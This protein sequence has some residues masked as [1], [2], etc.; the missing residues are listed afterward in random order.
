[1]KSSNQLVESHR[2]NPLGPL[3]LTLNMLPLHRASMTLPETEAVLKMHDFVELYNQNG[4]AGIF[5]VTS[6]TNTYRKTRLI[7]LSHGLDVF[8]DSCFDSIETFSGTVQGFLQK[9]INAQ[10]QTVGT[11]KL[12]TLGTC[13]DT[14][15]WTKEIKYDNLL[16]C[17]TEIARTE[18]DYVFTF[19]QNTLPWT[20]NFVARN[21]TVMSEFRLSRNIENC[22]VTFDDSDLCTRLHLSVTT[23]STESVTDDDGNVHIAGKKTEEGYYTYNDTSAQTQWGV[24]AK[25]AGVLRSEV[26]TETDLQTWVNAYFSR[27]NTPSLQI[28]IGGVELHALTG[29]SIDEAYI[30]RICQVALP[31]YSTYFRERI[32]SV[33]YPDALR[34]PSYV[35]V[36]LA[37]KRQTAED[38]FSEIRHTASKA[39]GSAGYALKKANNNETEIEKEKIRYDLQVIKDEKRFAVIASEDWYDEM[40]DSGETLI[41][42]YTADFEATA[43]RISSTLA[44]TGV[45]VDANGMPVKNGDDY[46]F[47][48]SGNTLYSQVTQTAERISAEVTRATGAESTLASRITQTADSITAEV[49]RATEAEDRLSSRITVTAEA[50][51]SKVSAGDIASTINQT[52]QSV[53]IQAQK[54]DLQGYVTATQLDAVRANITNLTTGVTKADYL[55]A[56]L[57]H[58]DSLCI[59]SPLVYYYPRQIRLGALASSYYLGRSDAA[60]PLELDHYHQLTITT[61]GGTVTVTLGLATVTASEGSANFNIADTAFYQNGVSAAKQLGW[62]VAA[63]AVTNGLPGSSNPGYTVTFQLPVNGSYNSTA[64]KTYYLGSDSNYAYLT[65]SNGNHVGKV[66]I[67]SGS[68]VTVDTIAEYQ[69]ADYVRTTRKINV[70]VRATASNGATKDQTLV[71]DASDAYSHGAESGGWALAVGKVT[72]PPQGTTTTFTVVVPDT[73]YNTD[74]DIDFLLTKD[75]PSSSGGYVYA[76]LG[77]TTVGR[78]DI[79]NWYTTGRTDGWNVASR[80]VVWPSENTSSASFMVYVPE[81]NSVGTTDYK[82]FAVSTDNNYAY[83]KMGSTVVARTTNTK[84]APYNVTSIST[85]V[86]AGLSY[87]SYTNNSRGYVLTG[88]GATATVVMVCMARMVVDGNTLEG[89]RYFTGS[90]TNL[91]RDAYAAGQTDPNITSVIVTTPAGA[92][93]GSY[94]N[95]ASGYWISGTGD[96]ARVVI[97]SRIRL[98]QSDDLTFDRAMSAAPTAVYKK[99]YA[100]GQSDPNITSFVISAPAN[101]TAGSYT[102]NS[103]GYYLSGAGTSATAAIVVKVAINGSIEQ[104]DYLTAAPTALYKKGWSDAN[105][106]YT[107]V[108][109]CRRNLTEFRLGASSDHMKLQLYYKSGTEYYACTSGT[110]YWFYGSSYAT[111]TYYTK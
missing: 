42:R 45:M 26:P 65:D 96:S 53:L 62:N 25:T 37:N 14:R 102:N 28:T 92:S 54:I 61:S 4:S 12:W 88:S 98:N 63:Q 103:S 68:S 47:N 100:D 84:T 70:Y 50:I 58:G 95:N 10:T 41:G 80:S 11:N 89:N 76:K 66:A 85:Q 8:S 78:I 57:L 6:I 39:G 79:S 24:V 90:A 5:R 13:E 44:V 105:A 73:T 23:E 30:G 34:T 99:G 106:Q 67:S 71:I 48:G 36:S 27:H 81:E 59:G 109:N 40:D 9:I 51:T 46:V 111:Y 1:M 7:E 33:N 16:E 93:E 3:N 87:G 110:Y 97:V 55:S 15:P 56:G 108:T 104:Y 18:E 72:E 75:S 21:N 20:L 74:R 86:N 101:A 2:L 83:V 29:V 43:R 49:T 64:A 32:V 69:T 31:T 77:S 17:L 19:S 52:A 107:T 91:Y 82:S 60:D 35:K 38:S 94:T 22:Q